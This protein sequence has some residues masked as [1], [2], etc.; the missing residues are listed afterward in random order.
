MQINTV[1]NGLYPDP[2][3]PGTRS[4]PIE[5]AGQQPPTSLTALSTGPSAPTTALR[6]ILAQYDV[7]DITPREFSEML[8]KMHKG[9]IISEE[10]L[11]DL[12]LIRVDLD[13]DGIDPDESIDLV[14]YYSDKLRK[15]TP[16]VDPS[17]PSADE[18]SPDG[19]KRRLNWLEKLALVQAS[20]DDVDLDEV[21]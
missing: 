10:E 1:R 19:L 18:P 14:D 21:A 15:Q 5:A 7:T 3:A 9:G 13:R 20:P 2:T 11:K 4:E 6:E 16:D 17:T 12:S 8:H